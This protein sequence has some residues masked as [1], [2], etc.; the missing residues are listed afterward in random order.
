[1]AGS[2]FGHDFAGVDFGVF[3]A[4]TGV[5]VC[6]NPDPADDVCGDEPGITKKARQVS[7]SRFVQITYPPTFHLVHLP[8]Q[9]KG[10]E[11]RGWGSVSF[12]VSAMGWRLTG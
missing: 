4:A 9:T 3:C 10:L 6:S 2:I 1:M 12:S 8:L 7:S 5:C 11:L